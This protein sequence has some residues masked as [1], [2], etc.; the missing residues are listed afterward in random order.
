M[1]T[2]APTKFLVRGLDLSR[3][4]DA[5]FGTLNTADPTDVSLRLGGNRV[6]LD[7][8]YTINGANDATGIVTGLDLQVLGNPVLRILG[9]ELS[10]ADLVDA[11]DGSNGLDAFRF[12]FADGDAMTGSGFRDV[13]RGFAG[14]DTLR[15]LQGNDSLHGGFGHDLIQGN[16][17]LDNLRGDAGNDTLSGGFGADTLSGGRGSDM[18]MGNGGDDVLDGGRGNDRL[19]G[20]A[21]ADS[22]VFGTHNGQDVIGDMTADDSIY[23]A[24]VRWEGMENARD[25]LDT[26]AEVRGGDVVIDFGRDSIRVL[27][28]TDLDTLADRLRMLGDEMPLG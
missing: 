7:G 10:A 27:N 17:G 11:L 18:L 26:Y 1:V 16:A 4:D 5:A 8:D 25:L 14:D 3:Y 15:G 9:L 6:V 28:W 2:L 22:F 23:I 19:R 12:L 21:G 13:L 24:A 20:G